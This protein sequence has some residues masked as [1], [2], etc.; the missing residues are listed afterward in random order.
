MVNVREKIKQV[1]EQGY[2]LS[3]GTYDENGPWVADVRYISDDDFNIYWMSDPKFRHSEA[4]EKIHKWQE[5][6]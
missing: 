5:Q 2:I 4:I 1:L 3:L 6:L